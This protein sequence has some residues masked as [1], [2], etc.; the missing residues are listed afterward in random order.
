MIPSGVFRTANRRRTDNAMAK[1]IK[2]K[3]TSNNLQ[4]TT[5]TSKDRATMKK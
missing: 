1:R 2:D 4:N 5:Q 3:R